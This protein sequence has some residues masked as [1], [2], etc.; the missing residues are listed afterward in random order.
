MTFINILAICIQRNNDE[1]LDY[2]SVVWKR[3]KK[4]DEG[5]L[6]LIDYSREVSVHVCRHKTTLLG[7]H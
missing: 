2:Q 7:V 6:V 3:E 4:I 1:D 5:K